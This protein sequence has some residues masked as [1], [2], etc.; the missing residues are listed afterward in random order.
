MFV[1]FLTLLLRNSLAW[2][3]FPEASHRSSSILTSSFHLGSFSSTTLLISQHPLTSSP[4]P[5]VPWHRRYEK[6][7]VLCSP[8]APLVPSFSLSWKSLKAFIQTLTHDIYLF[9]HRSAPRPLA[10]SPTSARVSCPTRPS[11][12]PS[13]RT[14]HASS[15]RLVALSPSSSNTLPWSRSGSLVAAAS[16]L[17]RVPSHLIKY[18]FLS[19]RL[20]A[21]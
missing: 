20:L 1:R 13:R 11:P 2:V 10:A 4:A 8:H 18:Y 14:P 21:W 9:T 19:T 3:P 12:T 15:N 6:I 16:V 7:L 17:I 5:W